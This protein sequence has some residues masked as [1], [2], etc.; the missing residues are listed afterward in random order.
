MRILA[1][2]FRAGSVAS[3]RYAGTYRLHRLFVFSHLLR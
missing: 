2:A 1:G 3:L